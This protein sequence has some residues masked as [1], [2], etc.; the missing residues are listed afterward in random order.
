MYETE[1][2]SFIRVLNHNKGGHGL[3]FSKIKRGQYWFDVDLHR[4]RYK[5]NDISW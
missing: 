1:D 4:I 5:Q 2:S 3:C